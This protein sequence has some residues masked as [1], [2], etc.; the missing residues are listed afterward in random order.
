M[1]NK[2]KEKEP[3]PVQSPE[4]RI[5]NFD[6]VELGYTDEIALKEAQ[7]CL[8]CKNKPCVAGCP[9]G[10]KISEFISQICKGDYKSAYEIISQN[11]SFP[12]VCGRVCPQEKQ[13]EAVCMRG[14]MGEPVA[15]GRLE[16]FVADKSFS[17]NK[18][19]NKY[20]NTPVQKHKIAVVGS[21][22][23]GLTCA[24]E[25][26]KKG[27]DVT[28]FEALHCIGGVLSYGIPQ[29]RLPRKILDK[30]IQSLKE[31]GVK[32]ITDAVIGKSLSIDKIFEKGYSAVYIS[33]GAGL[34]KFMGIKGESLSG[35]YSA[36]EFL[37]RIN[38]MKAHDDKYDTPLTNIKNVIVVGGGNVA[39]D[40]AR[41][42]IRVGAE[43]VTVMYRRSEAEMPAR[44]DEINH[45]KEE[46]IKFSF[47]S[48]P[49]EFYG[50]DGRVLGAK[51]LKMKF[52]EEDD[53]GRRSVVP[54]SDEKFDMK[55]DT[56]IVAIGNG[57]NSL[58]TDSTE[59]LECDSRGRIVIKKGETRTSKKGVYAG[60]DIVTGAAT[61]ILA[62]GA[63]K[64]A[65]EEIAEDLQ[66]N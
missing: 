20:N 32:I 6:E 15:I 50:E 10:V 46:G 31:N 22:P 42:A 62:M 57:A 30:E 18:F 39:M 23:A 52:S 66:N 19:K 27:F 58:I 55:A 54:V 63:G 65:A 21:G 43:S 25:L 4:K 59:G 34:P 1:I 61:V 26:S 64:K 35:I 5:K 13:C 48:N 12:A 47:L 36:N 51:Y 56:V 11:N 8:N 37:T 7:R 14:K 28:I 41:C 24:S 60:G 29:F 44:L 53:T 3:M 40:A 49:V 2:S 45:A 33:T 16:R 9:V 38:L 17:C